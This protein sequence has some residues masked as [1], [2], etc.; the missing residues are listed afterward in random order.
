[1]N[2][3]NNVIDNGRR[4]DWSSAS[5][6]YAKY[7]DIYPS[8]FLARIKELSLVERGMRVLD[9]G[10]GT[11]VL[12]RM[13]YDTGAFFVG[14]DSAAGQI[15]QARTI[16][17]QNGMNIDFSIG[18]AEEISF[19]E[20]SFDSA[21]ACQCFWY[22]NHEK[23]SE[24]LYHVLKPNG[25]FSAMVMEWLPFED[26]TAAKSEELILKYNPQWTGGGEIRHELFVP[27]CYGEYF[28]TMLS[29]VFDIDVPFT[30]ESW[31]GRI[32]SCRGIGAALSSEEVA[33]FDTE[34]FALL[35]EVVP[36]R[37]TIKHYAAFVLLKSKKRSDQGEKK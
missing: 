16:A 36:E 9:I 14:V 8:E 2:N 34:H 11:G 1:M 31:C 32:R 21:L 20:N 35:K 25:L 13:L 30:R 10:T 3:I 24:R 17:V 19:P 27:Q 15:E 22:F 4:Y 23:L 12:P 6:D 29:E 5:Q 37:F 18:P 33:R 28:D 26:N 7:R